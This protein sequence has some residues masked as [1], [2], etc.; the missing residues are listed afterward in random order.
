V[1]SVGSWPRLARVVEPVTCELEQF[2][3][4]RDEPHQSADRRA[5]KILPPVQTVGLSLPTNV[6]PSFIILAAT[7]LSALRAQIVN[8]GATNTLS[9]VTN[10][11]AGD[12]TVGT[13]GSFMPTCKSSS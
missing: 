1:G 8:D 10:S 11:F 3:Q 7:L 5:D 9:N 2:P 12:V 6:K 4:R 13:N